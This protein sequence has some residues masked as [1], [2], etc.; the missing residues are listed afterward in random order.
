MFD[1]NGPLLVL[2]GDNFLYWKICIEAYLEK[3]DIVIF[4]AAT[5]G[6]PKPNNPT[7]L[8]GDEIYYEKWNT[9]AKNPFVET[10]CKDVFNRVRNHKTFSNKAR[11]V[12]L[13]AICSIVCVRYLVQQCMV[14]SSLQ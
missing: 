6:L 11:Y 14:S 5:Q 10:F 4:R 8:I 12:L 13:S 2:E 3:I 9:N 7:N 1:G